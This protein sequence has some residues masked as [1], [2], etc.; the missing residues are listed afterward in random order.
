MRQFNPNGF[1]FL[2]PERKSGRAHPYDERIAAGPRFGQYFDALAGDEAELHQA[3]FKRRVGAQTH[4]DH[5]TR[6]SGRQGAQ[7]EGSG[8]K[9]PATWGGDSIHADKYD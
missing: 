5:D 2:A 8:G 6:R 7:T 1:N 4:A 3:P 9:S